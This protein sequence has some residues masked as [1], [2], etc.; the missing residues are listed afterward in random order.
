MG[1]A[2][3]HIKKKIHIHIHIHTY[4]NTYAD[5]YIHTHT[6]IRSPTNSLHEVQSFLRT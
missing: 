5:T 6:H 2:I 1:Q 3:N 4:I